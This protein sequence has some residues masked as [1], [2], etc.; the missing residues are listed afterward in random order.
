MSHFITAAAIKADPTAAPQPAFVSMPGSHHSATEKTP[1][2]A[3]TP[4]RK[5]RMPN[6]NGDA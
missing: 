1:A 3:A 6:F 5:F 4:I 2:K